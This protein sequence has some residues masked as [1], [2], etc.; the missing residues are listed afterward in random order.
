VRLEK[1]HTQTMLEHRIEDHTSSIAAAQ[2]RITELEEA[3]ARRTETRGDQ[4]RMQVAGTWH[5]DRGRAATA[6]TAQLRDLLDAP[7][8][9]R[10][11]QPIGAL[12]GFEFTAE[13]NYRDG[14]RYAIIRASD[15][16]VRAVD[17]TLNES[18]NP[19]PG[20]VVRIENVVRAL[21]RQLTDEHDRVQEL[22]TE[23]ERSREQ[24]GQPFKH[25]DALHQA[26]ADRKAINDQIAA[27]ADP[28]PSA[29]VAAE[30]PDVADSLAVLASTRPAHTELAHHRPPGTQTT[31]QPPPLRD[32]TPGLD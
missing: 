4:F 27:Q 15:A 2:S 17:M 18:H 12:G 29:L 19:A 32:N 28:K 30:D 25:R 1:S 8:G 20:L 21:D 6:L 13:R 31:M 22:T 26:Y 3:I 7:P 5:N 9:Y 11:P 24:L 10:P 14:S 16:P 23:I